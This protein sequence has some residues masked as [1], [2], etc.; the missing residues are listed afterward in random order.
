MGT[1][2]RLTLKLREPFWS[3]ERFARR[4]KSQS[5]DRLAFL[6]AQDEDFPVW[7]TSYPV[8][9]PMLIGWCGGPRAHSL[10]AL[11]DEAI[12]DKAQAA[13]SRQ[14]GLTR[15]DAGRMVTAA[16]L[17]NW[18][19]DPY[20]RGA[21]SYMLVDGNESPAKLARPVKGTLFFA[22]EASD[23]EGRTGTVH[24]AIATGKRAAKQV[25]RAL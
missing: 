9:A 21:Y 11:T 10:A 25:L 22:G 5:L 16:W 23:S 19:I 1:V 6:H 12:I 15:R 14:F 3:S 2:V 20:A 18:R 4:A 24:G 13:L 7:W 8:L 17:H